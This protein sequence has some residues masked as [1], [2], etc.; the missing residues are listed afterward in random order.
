MGKRAYLKCGRIINTH[1]CHGGVKVE[2]YCDTPEI[3]AS[4]SRIFVSNPDGTLRE[5]KIKH[6][7][8]FRQF[9][10]AE[11]AEVTDMDMALAMKNTD[12]YAF[13]DDFDLEEG[14]YFLVDLFGLPVLHADTG[15]QLGIL[16]NIVNRGASDLYVIETPK[17]E[18]LMPVVEEF[19]INVDVEKGIFVRPIPGMLDD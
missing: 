15:E 7:S 13:R 14:S 1:G 11:L 18:R 12:V 6:A 17:G 3:L 8:V 10:I 5:I 9:V 19:V 2:S 4:L 16:R